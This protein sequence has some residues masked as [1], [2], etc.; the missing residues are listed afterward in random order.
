MFLG[1][2]ATGVQPI[3]V[4]RITDAFTTGN[5]VGSLILW[6]LGIVF[7]VDAVSSLL[8][9][10]LLGWASETFVYNLRV[11]LSERIIS[12]DLENLQKFDKGDINNRFVEDIPL[13]QQPYFDT[14]PNLLNSAIISIICVAGLF[15]SSWHLAVAVSVVFALSGLLVLL[16][17]AKVE[18]SAR[19]SRVAESN[20]SS[21]LYESL[22]NFLPLKAVKSEHWILKHLQNRARHAKHAGRRLIGW[23]A[24]ILPGVNIATQVSL[25]IVILGGGYLAATEVISIASLAT[26]LLFLVYMVS[27]LLSM[28]LVL[29]D[30]KESGVSQKRLIDL[31]DALPESKPDKIHPSIKI[32][33]GR[34]MRAKINVKPFTFNYPDGKEVNFPRITINGPKYLALRGRNGSGKTTL[35]NLI[36]GL[37]GGSWSLCDIDSADG[38]ER[39]RVYYLPQD[40][41][42]FSTSV[43][44]NILL[45][46]DKTDSD[47][48]QATDIIGVRNFIDS[49]P[50]GL[51]TRLGPDEHELS[52]GQKQ[53]IHA[54]NMILAEWD[55]L[56]L[57]EFTSNID[58]GTRKSITKYLKEASNEKMIIMVS[59]DPEMAEST[60]ETI[61]LSDV[62]HKEEVV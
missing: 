61:N 13:S 41:G 34:D 20:Y 31:Y 11:G 22:Y 43:R 9:R 50:N 44:D 27:P 46:L 18:N 60:Q 45:G 23:N 42:T 12:T 5:N 39:P 16:V 55:I 6:I 51:D 21:F 57:D 52:G 15:Y 29:G 33:M 36:S 19:S 10:L 54:L 59:H 48:L 56:L 30:L 38:S 32:N 35:L 62:Y 40:R 14:Y 4:G 58:E 25:V 28:A 8:S 7:I 47:I 1:S 37:Q 53:I 26:F 24:L 17:L 49:L 3:L 2:L